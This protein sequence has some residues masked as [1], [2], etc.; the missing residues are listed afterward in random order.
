[1][2]P[3]SPPRASLRKKQV[4]ETHWHSNLI[5]LISGLYIFILNKIKSLI[6]LSRILNR[7]P[8]SNWLYRIFD[9][10]V[11]DNRRLESISQES[12]E[13]SVVFISIVVCAWDVDRTKLTDIGVSFWNP[14]DIDCNMYSRHWRIK[15]NVSLENRGVPNEPDTFTFGGTNL[16]CETEIGL[17][18]D[19]FILSLNTQFEKVVVVGYATQSTLDL[20]REHWKPSGSV[21]ILDTQKIWQVQHGQPGEV[22]LEEALATTPGLVFDKYLL[23]NAG[24]DSCFIL[25]LLQVQ[26]KFDCRFVRKASEQ[27]AQPPENSRF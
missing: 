1:M 7:D 8:F 25:R 6:S 24:N 22:T 15:E 19:E 23:R 21:T 3:K 18:L 5:I 11:D 26:G 12:C 9:Q 27:H 4:M 2:D 14:N 13:R 10:Y 20:L 17:L 16:I